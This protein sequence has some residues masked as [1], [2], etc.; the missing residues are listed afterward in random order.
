MDQTQKRLLWASWALHLYT[1]SGAIFGVLALK[2]AVA[3]D[4]LLAFQW[5]FLTIFIDG[6]DG[7]IARQLKVWER[8][9][10]ID[11]RRLDDIVDYFTYV[12]VPTAAMV[13]LGMLP[14]SV[15]VWAPI[16]LASAIGFANVEA[17][18]ED[19]YFMGF[20]SYW[21]LV[22]LYLFC[23]NWPVWAN[24]VVILTLSVLVFAPIRF[25]YPS[26][27][28]PFRWLTVIWGLIWS[29][30]TFALVAVPERLP[31]WWLPVAL[32]YP[33]YYV[34]LSLYLNRRPAG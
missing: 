25:I 10:R 24:T 2:A 15:F 3:G 23:L 1:A 33:V 34:S 31:E 21:N 4:A 32:L 19:D 9:P 7:T 26:K 14:D 6:T 16:L 20:P 13:W 27:T 12:A 30:Q 5:M 18:T 28:K 8:L 29:V 22:A 17:K 11:G